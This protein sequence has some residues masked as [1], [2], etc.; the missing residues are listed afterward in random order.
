MQK[1]IN[2]YSKAFAVK[3]FL[4]VVAAAFLPVVVFAQTAMVTNNFVA[5]P[6]DSAQAG[7]DYQCQVGFKGSGPTT[8][9]YACPTHPE[10][11][12]CIDTKG[13][14]S[15]NSGHDVSN[16]LISFSPG[17]DPW[18]WGALIEF[19]QPRNPS[20]YPNHCLT[21]CAEV[22][23]A[24][25]VRTV[26]GPQSATK[27]LKASSGP[28][29]VQS[30]LFEIFK[31]QKNANPYNPDSTPPIRTIALYPQDTNICLGVASCGADT[32][33]ST[34]DDTS[35]CD[36]C[37]S[38]GPGGSASGNCGR[39]GTVASPVPIPASEVCNKTCQSFPGY[40]ECVAG[41][42]K[43]HFCAPW[44]GTYEIDGEFGK[45]N[46]QFGYRTTISS[47]WPGD[48]VST[49]DIDL[50][51]TIV[52]PGDSQIPI[53]VDVTNVHSVRSTATLIGARVAVPAQPYNIS[54]RLSKDATVQLNITSAVGS[55]KRRLVNGEPRL[56]EGTPGGP[57][58]IDTVTT[59]VEGW[60]GLGDNG[61]LLPA[62]N[63]LA[64]IQAWTNDEWGW[65][66]SRAVTRQLSLD[67]LKI[68]DFV[69]TPL[70]KTSTA[71]AMLSYLLTESATVHVRI[72]QT[73][74][75]F[76]TGG[77]CMNPGEVF[78]G[79]LEIYG[80][81]CKRHIGNNCTPSPTC[82]PCVNP[83]GTGPNISDDYFTVDTNW[84]AAFD[85]AKQGRASVNTK[86][87]GRCWNPNGC[88][89]GA[90]SACN[91][92]TVTYPYGAPLPDGEYT[93]IIWADIPYAAGGTE[94]VNYFV[95]N[96][97]KTHMA[98]TGFLPIDRGY[99]DITIQAMGYSTIGSSPTAFGLDPFIIRYSLSRDSIVT[100]KIKTT[101]DPGGTDANYGTNRP[102]FTVKTLFDNQVKVSN[103]MNVETWDGKDEQGRYVTQ[104]TY[105][106]EI[107][108]K[109]A[110]FPTKMVTN[111]ILFPVDLFRVVDV[112]TTPILGE[113][114][115]QAMISYML[116]KSMSV[117]IDVYAPDVVIPNPSNMQ[118]NTWPPVI[119]P[120][121]APANNCIHTLDGVTT[122][123]LVKR[124]QGQRPGE[125]IMVTEMWDGLFSTTP[126]A[127]QDV[128][129]DGQYPYLIYATANVPSAQYY[130]LFPT[131]LTLYPVDGSLTGTPN[132]PVTGLPTANQLD[133]QIA[134]DRPTGHIVI[135]R[136]PVYFTHI[137]IKPSIP[138]LFFSSESI[139]IPTYEVQFAVTRTAKVT[140]EV[141]S[142]SYGACLGPLT[143]PGTICRTLTKTM[144]GQ[145]GT[146]YDPIVTHKL[147]WDGKD[148]KGDYVRKDAYEV[149]FAAEPYPQ[150][151]PPQEVTIRSEF[152]NVNNFQVFDRYIW[153]VTRQ[154]NGM[155]KFA[156][157]VS[158]PMKVSIQIFK[159]G[160]KVNNPEDG[161]LLDPATGNVI[162]ESLVDQVLVKSITGVR[163]HLVG[164][165]D[166]WDGTDFA[167][168]RVPDGIY[169][170]RYVTVLDSYDMDS[171]N[172]SVRATCVEPLPIVHPPTCPPN[173]TVQDKVADWDKFI[174]LGIINVANGDSWFADLDWKDNRV[175]MFFPNP[176]KQSSGQF[177][178]TKVPAPGTVTIKIYNIAGDLVRDSGYPCVNARGETMSLDQI[179][180]TGG[181]QPDWSNP[182]SAPGTAG[183]RNFAL[184][185]TWDRNNNHKKSVARGLY[186]AIMELNPTRGNAP[187]SQ[188]VIKILIP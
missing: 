30:I 104:G 166:I 90:N 164:L 51:H 106:L 151:S 91:N 71:Y 28:F 182:G 184:R 5:Y 136:G 83:I 9:Y 123:Q 17:R 107:T 81:P 82:Y 48:G 80:D 181:I 24:N 16:G 170:F 173:T 178:I 6:N 62:G 3:I 67:P 75:S 186:Y 60:D 132:D 153:D 121:G 65:D 111:T 146:I 171:I 43:L 158:V 117:N 27:P 66:K 152:L 14:P 89:V 145:L 33:N 102:P 119:C 63:Y 84:F 88:K 118:T 155:G 87:D 31:Y 124:F 103:Q 86:W 52:Y 20:T 42:T 2:K 38:W 163:P 135:A 114:T 35:C 44:D 7:N 131:T 179:N 95:W 180:A 101:A 72:Y 19:D 61:R 183:V 127:S 142:N 45:S 141:R 99:P 116:S 64:T 140:I 134:S 59:E 169:P 175:T 172:G 92:A 162:S 147:Y 15:S 11:G 144:A 93:Y 22:S 12:Y 69:V 46:G 4:L 21:L 29:P 154:N 188:K 98:Y 58:K 54:Y 108:A 159:P 25:P 37:S 94:S 113:A 126:A 56:G 100:A 18:Q 148:E 40:D 185:C 160:T 115:S 78:R 130:R 165:E 41:K 176:L 79:G 143:P 112:N 128:L 49:P 10:W 73:G 96:G 120:S 125:G 156:Y 167:G 36:K 109:D 138:Q 70:N 139:Y 168:Q 23:C 74:Q 55:L 8:A 53:Q 177:E 68:T 161:T 129:P 97:V 76:A 34:G 157:Q 39:R 13:N 122:P 26:D 1:Q 105:M 47:K 149:R 110:L 32:I 50:S 174:N 77:S 57:D 85:E 187:K 150:T 137:L 133:S